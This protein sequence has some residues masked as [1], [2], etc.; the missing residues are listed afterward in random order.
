MSKR[1][2]FES[3]FGQ[4]GELI[5]PIREKVENEFFLFFDEINRFCKKYVLS[6]KK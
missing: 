1:T 4:A 2:T 5:F 3:N 6:I